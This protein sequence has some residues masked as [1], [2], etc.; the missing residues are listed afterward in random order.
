MQTAITFLTARVKGPD[1][2]DWLK[3]VRLIRYLK[4]TEE[5]VLTLSADCL[6]M[7]K[8]WVDASCGV[9][10]DLKGHT[11][12]SFSLGKGTIA[13]KSSKQKLNTNCSTKSELVGVDDAM[14][15]CLWTNYFL[16]WQQC[17]CNGTV[18]CQD[19]SLIHI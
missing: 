19:L 11:G 13:G 9:H 17:Q 12:V 3:L 10:K 2:D 8:W 6:N 4:G 1:E 15:H 18:A 14:P 7:L 5:M 16:A